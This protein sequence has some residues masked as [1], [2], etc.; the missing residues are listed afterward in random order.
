MW[1]FCSKYGRGEK[2][3]VVSRLYWIFKTLLVLK[4]SNSFLFLFSSFNH[5]KI[6]SVKRC[7]ICVVEFEGMRGPLRQ[8]VVEV[9]C[10]EWGGGH[11]VP[12]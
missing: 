6:Q 11:M 2:P 9:R 8:G 5:K 12:Y 3:N 7:Y 10:E 1:P 4:L